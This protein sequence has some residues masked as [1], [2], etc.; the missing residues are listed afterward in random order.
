MRIRADYYRVTAE[1][2]DK[3]TTELLQVKIHTC[4]SSLFFRLAKA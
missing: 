1:N 2:T 4:D 3:N